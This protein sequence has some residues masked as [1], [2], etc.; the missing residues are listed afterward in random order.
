MNK[1][2]GQFATASARVLGSTWLFI[3]MVLLTVV[4]LAVGP[5][6]GFSDT[7]QLWA[8]TSTT[9]ATTWFVILVQHT[10]NKESKALHAKLDELLKVSKDARDEL[11]HAEDYSE[12]EIEELRP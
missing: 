12:D 6:F 8:N 9:I 7:W 10:Q 5:L 4:W 11:M 2:F 1:W 3:A